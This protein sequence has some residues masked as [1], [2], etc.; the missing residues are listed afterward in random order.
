[1]AKSKE[2]QLLLKARELSLTPKKIKEYQEILSVV[3]LDDLKDKKQQQN[4]S[5]IHQQEGRIMCTSHVHSLK[6]HPKKHHNGWRCDKMK[7]VNRC[8]SGITDFYQVDCV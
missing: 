8:L 4:L 1:M 6:K 3:D 7:G 2:N 5:L